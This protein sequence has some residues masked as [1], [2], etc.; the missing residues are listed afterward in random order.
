MPQK[1]INCLILP[2]GYVKFL[3]LHSIIGM[4]HKCGF[5]FCNTIV[6]CAKNNKRSTDV[7]L[8]KRPVIILHWLVP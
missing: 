2:L 5:Q 6:I 7:T 1:K 3:T 8:K 4:F